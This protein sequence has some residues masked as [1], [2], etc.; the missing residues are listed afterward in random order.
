MQYANWEL[1]HRFN[2]LFIGAFIVAHLGNH[3]LAVI[4]PEAHT[5]GLAVMRQIY[6]DPLF[7]M[8]LFITIFVQIASG[9]LELKFIGK[10]GW[11]LV[12]NLSGACL[13]WFMIIHIGTVYYTRYV[14]HIPTDFY[15][16]AGSFAHE[17]I[18][19]IAIAFYGLGVFSFFAHVIAVWA[20]AWKTMPV[21]VQVLSWGFGATTTT[22]IL[23]A[24]AGVFYSIEIPSE[25]TEYYVQMVAPGSSIFG[26]R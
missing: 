19:Y 11:K 15:W 2:S 25:M 22:L 21:R 7:E 5:E 18:Q 8:L 17:P 1:I 16:V 12:R 23:L 9:Y 3:L 6:F 4:S 26:G 10:S 13:M 24:F 14:D 20:L